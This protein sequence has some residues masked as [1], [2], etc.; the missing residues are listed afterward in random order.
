MELI[1]YKSRQIKSNSNRLI[2]SHNKLFNVLFFLKEKL[3]FNVKSS[4][5]ILFIFLLKTLYLD[6]T[7]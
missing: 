5:K 2:K 7:V 6:L 3:L 4:K 1:I